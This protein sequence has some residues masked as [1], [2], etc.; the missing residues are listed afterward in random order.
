MHRFFAHRKF[1]RFHSVHHSDCYLDTS[2]MLRVNAIDE[3]V[4]NLPIILLAGALSLPSLIIYNYRLIG[5]I[6]GCFQ[7]S[8][9]RLPSKLDYILA[10]VINTPKTHAVHHTADKSFYDSNFASI[11]TIWDH[12]FGT[13][14]YTDKLA[15]NYGT[16]LNKIEIIDY[17]TGIK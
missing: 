4:L 6:I 17:L 9:L 3:L 10:K 16:T 15:G 11:F 13:F 1:W 7:H 2:T 14:K 8:N 5:F 12:L